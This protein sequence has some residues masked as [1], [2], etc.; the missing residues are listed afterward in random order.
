MQLKRKDQI[1]L[2]HDKD[3][4]KD[5]FGRQIHVIRILR[6]TRT[7][8]TILLEYLRFAIYG[9][10]STTIGD[11]I[12]VGILIGEGQL[13]ENL[14]NAMKV[15]QVKSAYCPSIPLKNN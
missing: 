9:R 6:K 1:K 8:L 3:L 5:P 7:I 13:E 10:S 4:N 12:S 11:Q 2:L 14:E 15:L